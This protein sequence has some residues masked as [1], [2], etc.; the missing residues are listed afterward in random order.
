MGGGWW[1]MVPERPEMSDAV[2]PRSGLRV[3]N[4]HTSLAAC[5]ELAVG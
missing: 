4:S 2:N 3:E 1:A 5:D